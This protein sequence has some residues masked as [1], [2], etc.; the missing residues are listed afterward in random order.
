MQMAEISAKK[1]EKPENGKNVRV[2]PGSSAHWMTWVQLCSGY[3]YI[4]QKIKTAI[5]SHPRSKLRAALF[6][7]LSLQA[8]QKLQSIHCLFIFLSLIN[9]KYY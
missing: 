3:H 5:L 2:F 9:L 4:C 6:I 7:A 1:H 8:L